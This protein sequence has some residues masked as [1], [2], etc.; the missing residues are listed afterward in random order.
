MNWN[1][2]NTSFPEL[3][4]AT[5]SLALACLCA[6]QGP[7]QIYTVLHPFAGAFDDGDTPRAG[8]ALSGN[9]LYGSTEGAG[10]HWSGVIFRI[11]K[12][13][14]DYSL[15]H[16]FESLWIGGPISTNTDGAYP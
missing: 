8:L 3:L 5:C 16:T 11:N 6:N 15:L 9:T 12:D 1:R 4:T 7:A 14:T 10:A 2:L 13:G